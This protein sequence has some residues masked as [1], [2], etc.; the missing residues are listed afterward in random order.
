MQEA[1]NINNDLLLRILAMLIGAGSDTTSTVLQNFFKTMALH[2]QVV[3]SAQ[4]S[5][6][7]AMLVCASSF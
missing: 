1:W 6:C 5:N 2:P 7:I 4:N 3:L